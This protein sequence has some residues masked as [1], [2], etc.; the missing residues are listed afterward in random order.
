VENLS[1]LSFI[2]KF[3]L[4]TTYRH[5][6]TMAS[7]TDWS[8]NGEPLAEDSEGD[9]YMTPPTKKKA[10]TKDSAKKATTTS[11][12][13]TPAKKTSTETTATK[14]TP[15]KKRSTQKKKSTPDK[16]GVINDDLLAAAVPQSL[17]APGKHTTTF[18]AFSD[19]SYARFRCC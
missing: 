2:C 5:P 18:I 11:E 13:K 12:K 15:A 8:A 9:T 19:H 4:S 14:P 17:E 10:A 7:D 3:F 1:L 6:S 16:R